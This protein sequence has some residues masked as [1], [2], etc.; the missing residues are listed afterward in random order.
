[1]FKKSDVVRHLVHVVAD[2]THSRHF[3]VSQLKQ[4]K[5]GEGPWYIPDPQD[6]TQFPDEM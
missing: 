2:P 3:E 4:E 6:V 1:M 5:V